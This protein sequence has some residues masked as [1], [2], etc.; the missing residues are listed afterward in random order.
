MNSA[1]FR[2]RPLP[3]DP[4]VWWS[5]FKVRWPF[6]IWVGAL[7]AALVLAYESRQLGAIEGFV[8]AQHEEAAAFETAVL[9][10]VN[11]HPGDRVRPG[12]VLATLDTSALD[13][14]IASAAAEVASEAAQRNLDR[15]RHQSQ[16]VRE[17]IDLRVRLHEV[18]LQQAIDQS[19]LDALKSGR[20]SLMITTERLSSDTRD[21]ALYE[22]EQQT[23]AKAVATYPDLIKSLEE[24]AR[25]L[26]ADMESARVTGSPEGSQGGDPGAAAQQLLDAMAARRTL[27]TLRA[28]T[29]GVVAEVL[30]GAGEVVPE[31]A[32]VVRIL[33]EGPIMV[34]ALV[35][36][37]EARGVATGQPVWVTSA[38]S[39]NG[40]FAGQI[41][42]ISPEIVTVTNEYGVLSGQLQRGRR[43]MARLDEAQDLLPGERV[44]LLLQNPPW[45]K[46]YR[47]LLDRTADSRTPPAGGRG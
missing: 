24:D 4:R 18:R 44:T 34:T 27:Y 9:T 30:Y 26:E 36:E 5:R 46:W 7:L 32:P 45:V 28:K 16:Y 3:R 40:A 17:L 22:V 23:L 43:V 33:R 20:S 13:S 10:T 15:A 21:L 37:H 2:S 1:A 11:V 39:G 19:R 42:I 8:E 47:G 6:L 12:D 41:A 29:S 31:G 25:K 35:P 14:D 38:T